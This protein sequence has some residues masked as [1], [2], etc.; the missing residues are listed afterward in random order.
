MLGEPHGPRTRQQ[1]QPCW[2]N[3]CGARTC[4]SQP[5]LRRRPYGYLAHAVR[6]SGRWPRVWGAQSSWLQLNESTSDA[7]TVPRSGCQS[8]D[9]CVRGSLSLVGFSS[10][11]I[12]LLVRSSLPLDATACSAAPSAPHTASATHAHPAVRRVSPPCGGR[13]GASARCVSRI[14]G[15]ANTNRDNCL[16]RLRG[17]NSE[18]K[19]DF[20]W[21]DGAAN[22][23]L[24][25]TDC[26]C[27]ARRRDRS[28]ASAHGWAGAGRRGGEQGQH[29]KHSVAVTGRI[30]AEF[31]VTSSCG[32]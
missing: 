10:S 30:Q 19:M 25:P 18:V 4:R 6:G 15:I 31:R 5:G 2:E 23:Q 24:R 32:R 3:R 28:Q 13:S 7:R 8:A 26:C 16:S 1:S 29:S 20:L 12:H 22:E 11:S 9:G 17:Q 21:R 27:W 14:G